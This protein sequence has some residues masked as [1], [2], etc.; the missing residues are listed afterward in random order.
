MK[1]LQKLM[2]PLVV[3]LMLMSLA[4]NVFA[5]EE[6]VCFGLGEEDCEI[7]TSLQDNLVSPGSTGF[8]M[9]VAGS[10]SA[11]EE[12]AFQV[13]VSGAYTTDAAAYQEAIDTFGAITLRDVSLGD[14]VTVLDGIISAWDAELFVDVSSTPLAGMT[15]GQ[16]IDLYFVDGVAYANLAPFGMLMGDPEMTGTYGVDAFEAI[17]SVLSS[18]TMADI[19]TMLTSMGGMGEAPD[20]EALMEA[21]SGNMA[22]NPF[23][24]GF[25][26]GIASANMQMSD[27]EAA[28]FAS[29]ERL[30]DEEYEGETVLVFQT[31][32]DIAQ[33]LQ[34][35]LVRQQMV[36]SIQ[37]QFAMQGAPEDLDAEALADALIESMAGSTVVVSEKYIQ[38]S[39]ILLGFD[40]AMDFTI[41]LEPIATAIG[42]E[43]G[44]NDPEAISFSANVTF[45][46]NSINA[47][48]S[49]ALPEDAQVVPLMSLL[50][51][52]Q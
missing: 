50:G 28:E 47:V 37:Q 29:M 30:A 43:M 25:Q 36:T 26:Q 23:M 5:Q 39:N 6:T 14:V 45:E 49:I 27:A 13:G 44:E 2:L 34:N 24:A 33:T 20:P 51:G 15:G 18:A 16:T 4:G 52:G 7:Y 40:M 32:V 42:E 10:L 17:D 19:G 1:H 9:T 21:F 3:I 22:D 8:E 48:E 38:S 35:P 12:M 31:T 41:A 11:P 46:R